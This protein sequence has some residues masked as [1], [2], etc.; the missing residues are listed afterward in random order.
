MIEYGTAH[1][2]NKLEEEKVIYH[3]SRIQPKD[4][5]LISNDTYTI[6]LLKKNYGTDRKEEQ[7]VC[8]SYCDYMRGG[9]QYRAI[10]DF[11][12]MYVPK[13]EFIKYIKKNTVDGIEPYDYEIAEHFGVHEKYIKFTKKRYLYN[14]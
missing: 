14:D 11:I 10:V 5:T 9:N 12:H 8:M 2:Y 3:H 13:D 4:Y 6:D 7:T 1:F